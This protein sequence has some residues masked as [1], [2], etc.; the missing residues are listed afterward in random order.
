M[1]KYDIG[2]SQPGTQG[3]ATL[4]VGTYYIKTSQLIC[5][6]WFLYDGG[7]CHKRVNELH[8]VD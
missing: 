2:E 7:L 1:E 6:D 5:L 4:Y 8:V 3:T